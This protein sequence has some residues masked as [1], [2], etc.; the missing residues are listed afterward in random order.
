MSQPSEKVEER[1]KEIE[2]YECVFIERWW[3]GQIFPT[4]KVEFSSLKNSKI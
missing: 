3:E 1:V 2:V 4:P